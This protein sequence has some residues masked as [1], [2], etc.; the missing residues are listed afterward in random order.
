MPT[1]PAT[2]G[3]HSPLPERPTRD[4]TIV[5]VAPRDGLQNYERSIQTAEKIA[6]IDALSDAGCPVIE[7]ASFVNPKAVP[8]MSD[9]AEVMRGISRKPGVRYMALVPNRK[10]LER[11]MSAGVESIGLFAA[12]TETFSQR[13]LNASVADALDRFREVARAARGAG[14]WMRGYVSVAFH[15]PFSG[16][17]DPADV[18]TVLNELREMGCD[19]FALADTNGMAVPEDVG[20]LVERASSVVPIDRLAL[21]LH[22]TRGCAVDNAQAGFDSG[23]RIFDGSAGGIGGCP[24]S[25]GAPGNVSTERLVEH[26]ERQGQ[27]TGID[28]SAV[29]DAY[30]RHIQK[31]GNTA[32]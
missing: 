11:A 8:L 27:R 6:L 2:S 7:A 30:R 23:A 22:D 18:L 29:M 28:A 16:P 3:E 25:P 19:E 15:C 21:H 1:Q 10:G 14:I 32:Y 13:N 26:F 9:S 20:T 12:A 24:F 4:V 31:S 17:V 5:E